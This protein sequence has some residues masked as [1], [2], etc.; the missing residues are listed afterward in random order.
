MQGLTKSMLI[1]TQTKNDLSFTLVYKGIFREIS[2]L[3]A[4]SWKSGLSALCTELCGAAEIMVYQIYTRNYGKWLLEI[5]GY[6]VYARNFG[7]FSPLKKI[8][9]DGLTLKIH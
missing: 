1:H 9:N 5:E 3:C 7:F 6:Q 8:E 4:R 2:F